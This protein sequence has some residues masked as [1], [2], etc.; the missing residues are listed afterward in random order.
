MKLKYIIATLALIMFSLSSISAQKFGYINSQELL[1]QM[2]KMKEAE[3]NLT[4]LRTQLEKQAQDMVTSYQT[5]V[6]ALQQKEA[7]GE[8]SPKQLEVEGISLQQEQVKINQF[9]QES[10]QKIAEKQQSLIQPIMD[11][12][13]TAIDDVGKENGFQYIFDQAIG[14]ILY[15][16]NST[17]VTAL[18]KAKLGI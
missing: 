8:L 2:P 15:A 5:K 4:T 12:V 7:Q 3:A 16:D 14:F 18:V 1:S 11:Q 6:Q 9:S 10:Q 17:D 13:Q